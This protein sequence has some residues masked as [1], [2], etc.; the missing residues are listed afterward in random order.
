MP[1]EISGDTKGR[2]EKRFLFCYAAIFLFFF[3][4]VWRLFDLQILRGKNFRIFSEIHTMKEI[5]VPASRGIIYDR[6]RIPIAESRAS[7]DLVVVPQ[8]I[9]N[10]ATLKTAL[11]QIAKVTPE[12]FDEILA[13]F[14]GLPP[15]YPVILLSDIPYDLAAKIR[16]LKGP[17]V[18]LAGPDPMKTADASIQDLRG[19]EVRARP[20]RSYPQGPIAATTLGYI[21][22]VSEKDLARL[23]RDEPGRYVPGDLMGQVGLEK[24]WEKYLRGYDGYEQ[25]VVDA[26][27]RQIFNEDIISLLKEEEAQHGDHLVLT[28]DSRVQKVAEESFIGKSGGLVAIDP[29][30]GSIIA[31]VS[32]PSYDPSQLVSNVSHGYWAEM[33]SDKRKLLLNRAIQGTYPPASTYKI[34]TGIAALSEGLITPQ[35]TINCPGG[36]QYGGRFFKC[37]NKGGHGAIS[38]RRALASSCDT[39]FYQLGLRLGVDRIAKYANLLG[40]GMKTGL[41]IDGEK[42]GLIPTAEWK[43]RVFKQEWQP[44]EN[45]SIS[46]GQGYDTVTPLQNALMIARVGTGRVIKPHLLKAIEDGEGTVLKEPPAENFETLPIPQNILAAVHEGL[47]DVVESGEGTARRIKIP[48]IKIAG[49]TGTAQ[50][51]SEEGKSRARGMNTEDHAWFVAYAP[52][53]APKIAV[54]AIVEHGGFGAAAAAPIVRN[55]IEKYLQIEG[56]LKTDSKEGQ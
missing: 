45:I 51:I 7:F 40:L 22:E 18:E 1:L 44:G 11:F 19:V 17:E 43:K 54:A 38:L 14:K 13:K 23:K 48:G 12:S 10:R 5:R 35:T 2:Y 49:K 9:R 39:Y 42:A 37:W 36:L 41:D 26:V 30:D 55:V 21:G 6:N 31:M 34:T 50:V 33:V 53:D 52:A 4:A 56:D 20:L 16:V 29:R 46:V 25:K 27:G 24:F 47:M 28:L 32:A 8:Q 15:Y 3:V